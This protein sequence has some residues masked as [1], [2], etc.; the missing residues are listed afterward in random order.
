ML[1]APLCEIRL[2]QE[3]FNSR[4]PVQLILALSLMVSASEGSKYLNPELIK[5]PVLPR[6]SDADFFKLA[7]TDLPV[8]SDP[9]IT[10]DNNA[11]IRIWYRTGFL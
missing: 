11:I 1:K 9:V 3:P 6:R 4:I 10:A 5:I 8:K 7:F 2:W